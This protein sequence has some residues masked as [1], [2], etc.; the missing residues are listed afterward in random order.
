MLTVNFVH[1][2]DD[3]AIAQTN[4]CHV[5]HEDIHSISS[6][7]LVLESGISEWTNDCVKR[8]GHNKGIPLSHIEWKKK[9]KNKFFFVLDSLTVVDYPVF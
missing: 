1:A 9:K 5:L 2:K 6:S 4:C 8:T 3:S 7:L